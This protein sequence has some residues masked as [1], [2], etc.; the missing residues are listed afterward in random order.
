MGKFHEWMEKKGAREYG[1]QV[2]GIAEK[3]KAKPSQSLRG[4]NKA[5]ANLPFKPAS[6]R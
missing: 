2:G 6:A 3:R 1:R 5:R 4:K